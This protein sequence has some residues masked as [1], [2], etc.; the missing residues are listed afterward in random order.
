MM[1][2]FSLVTWAVCPNKHTGPTPARSLVLSASV[3]SCAIHCTK[4]MFVIIVNILL[5]IIDG[6]LL[7]KVVQRNLNIQCCSHYYTTC[8]RVHNG[9]YMCRC[10]YIFQVSHCMIKNQMRVKVKY[11]I[12]RVILGHISGVTLHD[13]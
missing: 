2:S 7:N 1:N 4:T 3:Y 5:L 9:V 11:K 13:E 10:T 12:R 6:L 8:V